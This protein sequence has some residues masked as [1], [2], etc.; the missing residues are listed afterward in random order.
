MT[1]RKIQARKL[2]DYSSRRGILV[3]ATPSQY[4]IFPTLLPIKNINVSN[5]LSRK[6]A[7]LLIE[8]SPNTPT[9]LAKNL[10]SSFFFKSPIWWANEQNNK[11]K[12]TRS[13]F[14]RLS[15]WWG[16]IQS[17]CSITVYEQIN[18]FDACFKRSHEISLNGFL[19]N[20]YE[21]KLFI[22]KRNLLLSVTRSVMDKTI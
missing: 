15:W 16:Q 6:I 4:N 5:R 13:I 17:I 21:Q 2:H 20:C 14:A 22:I 12:K 7:G 9:M 8:N 1:L 11:K 19:N 18:L 10:P 3:C